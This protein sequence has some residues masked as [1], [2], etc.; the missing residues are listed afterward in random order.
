MTTSRNNNRYK[1]KE[2][3]HNNY[4]VMK[5]FKKMARFI[6]NHVLATCHCSICCLTFRGICKHC[7]KQNVHF[8]G[9]SVLFTFSLLSFD[10]LRLVVITSKED[11][12]GTEMSKDS[13]AVNVTP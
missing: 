2:K 13:L 10:R 5:L 12:V 11:H 8:E 9:F 7:L 1:Y 4:N 3:I 6:F